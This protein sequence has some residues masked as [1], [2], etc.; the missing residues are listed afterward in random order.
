MTE[1]CLMA[2]EFVSQYTKCIVTREEV[3]R[4]LYYN[5]RCIASWQGLIA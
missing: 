4:V 5:M 1:E 3:G 2:R